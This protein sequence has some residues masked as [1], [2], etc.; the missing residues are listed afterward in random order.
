MLEEPNA[1][2]RRQAIL[3]V[4]ATG[5]VRTQHQLQQALER[6]GVVTTQATLSR[7]LVRLG[8]GKLRGRYCPPESS[9]RSDASL[10]RVAIDVRPAV[11]GFDPCGPNL[12]LVRT[13]PGQAQSVGVDIDA[14]NEPAIAGTV[15]GDDTLFLATRDASDQA[16]ALRSLESWYGAPHRR[17]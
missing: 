17:P 14:Q 7:D 6:R 1:Q 2:D 9:T 3:D 13:V 4:V 11:L 8:V 12:I 10:D 5:E 15:A 16:Q